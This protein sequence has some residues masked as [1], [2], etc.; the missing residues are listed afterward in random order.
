M[1]K[2]SAI[3]A[4]TVLLPSGLVHV[5]EAGVSKSVPISS[6]G[7]MLP[8]ALPIAGGTLLSYLDRGG[9]IIATAGAT[10]T[11]TAAAS[12]G[13]GWFVYIQN[14]STGNLILDPN[15]A[16]TI[17]GFATITLSPGDTTMLACNGVSFSAMFVPSAT[18]WAAV[19]ETWAFA[20]ATT[21]TVPTDA[22]TRFQK[23]DRIRFTQTTVKYF[24]VV[25]VTATVLTV[26][27]GTDYTVAN[28]AISLISMSRSILPFGFPSGFAYTPTITQGGT[29]TSFTTNTMR[30][31][32]NGLVVHVFGRLVINNAGTAAGANQIRATL[33]ITCKQSAMAIGLGN[34]I[35]V[36]V[37]LFYLAQMRLTSATEMSFTTVRPGTAPLSTAGNVDLGLLDF[38]AALAT[39]DFV[40]YDITY[41]AA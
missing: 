13:N 29:V 32:M 27:G 4:S 30:F 16:E 10:W 41:E 22:T 17:N 37:A 9:L 38:V 3:P 25:A 12:L 1:T 36:S 26:T 14:N 39:N 19:N 20:T 2:I 21:I 35:D 18:G 33:P 31:V 28:A 5:D 40:E 24:Y 15:G 6:I 11:L 8:R 7:G 23:G 34:I